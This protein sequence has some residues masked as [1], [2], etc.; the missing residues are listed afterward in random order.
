MSLA[1]LTPEDKDDAVALW[2]TCGL[3]VPWNDAFVDFDRA[4]D[5]QTST[6][7]GLKEGETLIGTVMVGYDGHRGWMYYLAVDPA[8]QQAQ[9][10]K[11]LV[12]AAENW[13]REQDCPKVQLMVR[14]SNSSVIGFYQALGYKDDDVLVLSRRFV[15]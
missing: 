14:S 7:L 5:T 9:H 4:L 8:H 6:V 12:K 1:I 11:R 3:T 2:T 15:P 13:L 10:G